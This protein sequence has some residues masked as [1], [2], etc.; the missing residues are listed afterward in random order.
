MW[1]YSESQKVTMKLVVVLSLCLGIPLYSYAQR[2]NE[3]GLK[4]VSEVEYKHPYKSLVDIIKFKYNEHNRLTQMSVY[5]KWIYTDE[6]IKRLNGMSSQDRKEHLEE[7]PSS[8]KLYR[9]FIK[10]EN[11]L[12]VK[13]YD[14]YNYNPLR[15]E[16]AFDCYENI[17]SVSVF[18]EFEPGAIMRDEFNFEYEP[19]GDN[20]T[21]HLRR[22]NQTETSKRKGQKSWYGTTIGTLYRDVFYYDGFVNTYCNPNDFERIKKQIDCNHINDTNINLLALI[23]GGSLYGGG[24]NMDYFTLTEWLPCR[25]KYFM[26]DRDLRLVGDRYE[27]LIVEMCQFEYDTKGNMV[28]IRTISKD[29]GVSVKLIY[30]Y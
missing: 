24:T 19:N 12:T 10:D 3:H 23:G 26:L 11:G 18:E 15:W 9:D 27:S 17:S 28:G 8:P 6:D 25:S 5:R 20:K 14:S 22:Y 1:I 2:V 7:F 30:L 4:M 21:F 16:V 29:N 13:D